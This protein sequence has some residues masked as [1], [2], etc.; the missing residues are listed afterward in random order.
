MG[1]RRRIPPVNELA[2]KA[3]LGVLDHTGDEVA[4][5]DL[6]GDELLGGDESPIG[7]IAPQDAPARLPRTS[8]AH[9]PR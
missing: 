3:R 6:T 9:V 1:K 5:F 2:D 4:F 8:G 7:Q